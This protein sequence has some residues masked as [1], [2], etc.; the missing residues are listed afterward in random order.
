ML[1]K[2]K[3]LRDGAT[4]RLLRVALS[5][6]AGWAAAHYGQNEWYLSL[7]PFLA[8]TGKKLRDK[9]PGSFD[10]LPF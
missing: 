9:Y 1:A 10:W 5:T 6:V 2:L 3:A 8:M 7:T 4:G